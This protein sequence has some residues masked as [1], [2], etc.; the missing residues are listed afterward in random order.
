MDLLC[1]SR[2]W[3]RE[4]VLGRPCPVLARAARHGGRTA[5]FR[6][7]FRT[8][9]RAPESSGTRPHR[10]RAADRRVA[11][12]LGLAGPVAGCRPCPG[13][14]PGAGRAHCPFAGPAR[15]P[16]SVRAAPAVRKN[17][18][19]GRSSIFS[20]STMCDQ[21]NRCDSVAPFRRQTN[22]VWRHGSACRC[23][24]Q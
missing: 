7:G 21:I 24:K 20:S 10:V 17:H 3:T 22:R 15:A 23:Q 11:L 9:G 2:V 16:T 12:P 5:G 14:P 19:P 4:E 13:W 6:A 18:A 1:L 8:A